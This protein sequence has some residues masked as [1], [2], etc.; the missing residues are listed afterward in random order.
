MNWYNLSASTSLV[1]TPTPGQTSWCELQTIRKRETALLFKHGKAQKWTEGCCCL[2]TISMIA[3]QHLVVEII[4]SRPHITPALSFH[5]PFL[6]AFSPRPSHPLLLVRLNNS[7][8]RRAVF[9]H[10]SGQM[11]VDEQQC[12]QEDADPPWVCINA[13]C[14]VLPGVKYYP[15]WLSYLKLKWE[16]WFQ[17]VALHEFFSVD[18]FWDKIIVCVWHS[19]Q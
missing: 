1:G 17:Y 16:K 8:E 13:A 19:Q 18:K 3:T 9:S 2:A 4:F 10:W 12:S 5:D 14:H 6:H 11:S 7:T 15:Y